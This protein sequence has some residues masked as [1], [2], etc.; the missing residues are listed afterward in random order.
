MA[1][2]SKTYRATAAPSIGSHWI[3]D[4]VGNIY[5]EDENTYCQRNSFVGTTATSAIH[6]NGFGI[7]LP[8]YAVVNS[9]SVNSKLYAQNSYGYIY[10]YF[11]S[12]T[13]TS[14]SA[15]IAKT[16]IV[17]G[18]SLAL[19]YKTQTYTAAQL[20]AILTELGLHSG[21][22][23]DFLKAARVRYVCGSTGTSN[24]CTTRVYDNNIVVNYTI[25][26]FSITINA[27]TGGTVSGMS[28]TYEQGTNLSLTAT[29]NA[30]YVFKQWS[31]G[32][33]NATR[34]ITVTAN[35]TYTAEFEKVYTSNL[36]VGT[37]RVT[38]YCGT[39]KM[40]AYCGTKKI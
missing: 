14:S 3:S 39:Q 34:T 26:E 35:A 13:N 27:G 7:N 32:N 10:V 4:D 36:F 6:I 2:Y 31:D 5:D 19:Q 37:Q 30:G 23:V 25:P 38:A 29:P 33:T 24:A 16:E 40:C 21:N 17:K 18:A 15:A 9:V 12:D 22:V 28:G 1:T 11:M 8:S 20:S